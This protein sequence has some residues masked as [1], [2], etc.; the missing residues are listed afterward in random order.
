[1][2]HYILLMVLDNYRTDS[3]VQRAVSL[4]NL[5]DRDLNDQIQLKV[6]NRSPLHARV[7]R[8]FYAYS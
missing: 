6:A 2:P 3:G 8:F 4:G 7:T 1:M 5:A